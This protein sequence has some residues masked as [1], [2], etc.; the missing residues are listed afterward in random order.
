MGFWSS[1][2]RATHP[3]PKVEADGDGE[4]VAAP[5]P[6]EGMSATDLASERSDERDTPLAPAIARLVSFGE[7]PGKDARHSPPT[8]EEALALLRDARRTPDEGLA[9]DALVRRSRQ[10][11]LPERL[12][13][14]VA[15]ALL[16]RGD[17]TSASALLEVT[18]GM[19]ALVV[20][21]DLLAE[22]GDFAGAI[23]AIERVLVRDLDVPGARERR[24]AWR[25]RLGLGASAVR[26]DP[27]TMT[28][29]SPRARAPFDLEREVARGGAG[30]VFAAKDRELGRVVALKV[31][32]QP[33]RDRAQLLDEGRVAAALEGP[34][35][36][37]VFDVEPNE[38]WLALEWASLGALR[39]LLRQS[40]ALPELAA[41]PTVG[42]G[43][44]DDLRG[45]TLLHPVDSWLVQL[46]EA[47]ARVHAAGWVH[48][49][50][51]PA[52]VLMSIDADSDG[53]ERPVPWLGDFGSA[54]RR[55]APSPP[56]SMGYVSPERL[57]GRASD[58]RD[59]V[60]GFGRVLEDVIAAMG[61]HVG[62]R[63]RALAATCVV[64]S[65]GRP[66]DGAALV[67]WLADEAGSRG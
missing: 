21:A 17:R 57:A 1:F 8:E 58:P 26:V 25:E 30:V 51:K 31:Y 12:A 9:L 37:R 60:Y 65:E 34:G 32:H 48:H 55:G 53:V 49:D 35:I 40:H 19:S 33:E 42:R 66:A 46:A 56:G 44:S 14:A 10:R 39:D 64:P 7:E 43:S 3:E 4:P 67:T 2:R 47:I 54:R 52:N 61:E 62:P 20:R 23:A 29:A 36:V 6:I 45:I 27:A 5:E 15:S 22:D 16:D 59:D 18:S 24:I 38:G 28:I 11:P 41:S 13:L 50:V 63:W